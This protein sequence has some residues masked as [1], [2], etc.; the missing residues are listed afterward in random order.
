M[1]EIIKGELLEPHYYKITRNGVRGRSV[2]V[3]LPTKTVLRHGD[4]I[5]Q[6]RLEP[7]VILIISEDKKNK[8][9]TKEEI[10]EIENYYDSLR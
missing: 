4:Q 9:L 3:N 7:G 8:Y 2:K 10:K 1:V 5:I 6:K